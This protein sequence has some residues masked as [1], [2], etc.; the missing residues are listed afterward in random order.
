MSTF[1]KTDNL[2]DMDM[3]LYP[4]RGTIDKLVGLLWDMAD[5]EGISDH[6]SS[7]CETAGNVL[8]TAYL[9]GMLDAEGHDDSDRYREFVEAMRQQGLELYELNAAV[10]DEQK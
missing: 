5:A 8:S 2:P 1:I 6:E 7:L 10:A 3:T 4:N 9:I